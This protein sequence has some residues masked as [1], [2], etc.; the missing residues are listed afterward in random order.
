MGVSIRGK[1]LEEEILFK[2]WLIS[3]LR[4]DLKASKAR[5]KKAAATR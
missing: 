1:G 4:K 5:A 3:H 2:E